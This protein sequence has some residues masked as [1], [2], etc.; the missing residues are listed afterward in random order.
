MV[1]ENMGCAKVKNKII[2]Q[3]KRV[4]GET[5]LEL[6]SDEELSA[7][8]STVRNRKKNLQIMA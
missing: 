4:A 8:I 2:K 1:M 3:K 6:S 5:G 7:Q